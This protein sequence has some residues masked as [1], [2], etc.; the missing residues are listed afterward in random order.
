MNKLIPVIFILPV[1][2]KV[3]DEQAIKDL[4][5]EDLKGMAHYNLS[6]FIR[7]I[8]SSYILDAC[9]AFRG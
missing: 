7:K 5:L 4:Q 1:N 9:T 6:I 8:K 2:K 3:I